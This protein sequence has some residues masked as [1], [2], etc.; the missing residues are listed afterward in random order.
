MKGDEYPALEFEPWDH[1]NVGMFCDPN[2]HKWRRNNQYSYS[3]GPNS[4]FRRCFYG[5]DTYEYVLEYGQKFWKAYE[6]RPKFLELSFLDSHEP[7]TEQARYIDDSLVAFLEE[8]DVT[9]QLDNTVLN[10]FADHGPHLNGLFLA[11]E[12]SEFFVNRKYPALFVLLPRSLANEYRDVLKENEQKLVGAYDLY[13]Y[14]QELLGN[15]KS[16]ERG[17]NILH[18]VPE[19]RQCDH[20]DSTSFCGCFPN[21]AEKSK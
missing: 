1:E 11:M 9:G 12:L 21:K 18:P 2:F 7:T 3:Q 14:K 13:N 4:L 17:L 19:D 16:S 8:L 10:I 15:N 20:M 6:D 5:R